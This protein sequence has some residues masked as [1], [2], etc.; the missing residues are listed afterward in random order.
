M[1]SVF[2]TK[3]MY[4]NPYLSS[5]CISGDPHGRRFVLSTPTPLLTEIPTEL[6]KPFSL[7]SNQ[8]FLVNCVLVFNL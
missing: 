6:C 3:G 2:K 5:L 7:L 1:F 4:K 8:D